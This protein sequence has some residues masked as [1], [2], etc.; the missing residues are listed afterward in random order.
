MDAPIFASY[1]N[2]YKTTTIKPA[3]SRP[4]TAGSGSNGYNNVATYASN[5]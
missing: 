4:R 2:E 5:A 1:P 3:D